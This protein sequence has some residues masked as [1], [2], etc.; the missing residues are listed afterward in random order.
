MTFDPTVT[1]ATVFMLANFV[2]LII[3][4]WA[5]WKMFQTRVDL[6]LKQQETVITTLSIAHADHEAHDEKMFSELSTRITELVRMVERLVG[7]DLERR[8]RT[9]ERAGDVRG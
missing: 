2:L 9:D 6:V 3:M 5:G 7:M 4:A 8:R 1:W